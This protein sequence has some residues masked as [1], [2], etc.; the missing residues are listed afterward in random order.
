MSHPLDR[1]VYLSLRSATAEDAEFLVFEK[2]EQKWIVD[3]LLGLHVDDFLG[4]GENIHC[5]R[6][7]QMDPQG[8]C[9]CFQNR[10]FHLSKRF[11][12]GSWDFGE[13][14]RFCGAEIKQSADYEVLT[15]SLQE[16]V[17]K[18]KPISLEKSRKTMVEDYCTEK[19][20]K[21]LR[22]LIGAMAWPVTQCIPQAAATLSILQASVN[23]PMIRDLLEANKCLRFMKEVVKSYVFTLRRHCDL[24]NL[25]IGLYCDAAWSVRPDGSS[26]GGM[27][28]FLASH[29]EMESD[30]PFPLTI[31]DW[32]SKKLVRMCR[33]SLSAEAQSAAIAVDELEWAKVFYATTANPYLPIH[34]DSTMHTFGES[35]VITDAKALFD[36]TISV[37]PW[38]EVVREED[39][40]RDQH[41]P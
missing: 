4:A 28:M 3:G 8:E 41:P 26:Q 16:Y 30:E 29:E 2:D 1:C 5:L 40:H 22:A 38:L 14:M 25:R 33:S 6:D 27:I 17:N 36:S 7:L 23:R 31:F 13:K 18:I 12:F 32:A 20:Q 15:V 37:T 9:S 24:E 34:E 39:S 19:E 35:P 10:L 11:K 21:H